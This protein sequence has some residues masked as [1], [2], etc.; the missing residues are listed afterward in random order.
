MKSSTIFYTA[1]LITL[2]IF[3]ALTIYTIN[4]DLDI[5]GIPYFYVS[6]IFLIISMIFFVTGTVFRKDKND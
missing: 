4:S 1:G 5:E 6:Y 2:C 3:W